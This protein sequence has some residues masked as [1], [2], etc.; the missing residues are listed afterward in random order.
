MCDVDIIKSETLLSH[1]QHPAVQGRPPVQVL[2][3]AQCRAD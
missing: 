1:L 3:H 2:S